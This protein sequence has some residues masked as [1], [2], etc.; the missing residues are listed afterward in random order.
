MARGVANGLTN[1]EIASELYV[2]AGTVKTHLAHIQAKLGV[3]N[4]VGIAAWAWTHGHAAPAPA[5]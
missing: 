5:V 3:R 1:A 2:T 4:R